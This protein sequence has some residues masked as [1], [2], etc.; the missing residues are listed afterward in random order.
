MAEP[1]SRR[2]KLTGPPSPALQ[3]LELLVALACRDGRL[4]RAE[5]QLLLT[6][7]LGG[8]DLA[9]AEA[10]ACLEQATA[11]RPAP[12]R[13]AKVSQPRRTLSVMLELALSDGGLTLN[14]VSF[15]ERTGVA[16]GLPLEEV[17]ATLAEGRARDAELRDAAALGDPPA[18][19]PRERG[20]FLGGL[21]GGEREALA[22]SGEA[23]PGRIRRVDPVF[24]SRERGP[25]HSR[26]RESV[27]VGWDAHYTYRHGDHRGVGLFR[28]ARER[29]LKKGTAV[30]VL[31]DPRASAR[32]TLDTRYW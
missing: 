17:R 30:W 32:S 24:A 18:P 15:I 22:R 29:E 9:P 13:A 20:G 1:S 8:L 16:L 7:A 19:P 4:T 25:L 28:L 26:T 11:G 12:P 2:V 6:Y 23:V 14:E 21:L 3:E 31:V 27:L 10:Q 5:R